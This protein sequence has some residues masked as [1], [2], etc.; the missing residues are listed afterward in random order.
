[1]TRVR[2]IRVA[3]I[4]AVVLIAVAVLVAGRGG[5]GQQL[6][7]TAYQQQV[8]S[9]Y[10]DVR[11]AFA[12]TSTSIASLHELSTRA[13]RAQAELRDAA[14]RFNALHAPM[15]VVAQNHEIAAGLDAYAGD[16]DQLRLAAD[17]G[18][19]AKVQAFEDGLTVNQSIGR[20]REAAEEIHNRGYN[21][22]ALSA[23]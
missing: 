16:L 11:Q 6:S 19:A 22:G 2:L 5:G 7:R 10:G 20:I 17:A 21:L 3:L 12:G 15:D 1:M 8:Q 14:E 9:I 13:Q 4:P 23:E 18:D